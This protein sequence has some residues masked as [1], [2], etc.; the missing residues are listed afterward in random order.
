MIKGA[1]NIKNEIQAIIDIYKARDLL[2]AELFCKKLLAKHPKTAFLF[3]LLGLIL[4]EQEKYEEAIKTYTEGIKADPKFAMIYNNLGL[5]Y[6][7]YKSDKDKAEKFFKKSISIDSN[8][9]EP[10]NNLGTLYNSLDRFMEAIDCYEKAIK[11]NPNFVQP[12]HN[13][14][15]TYTT[16]GKFKEA[17]KHFEESLKLDPS[18]S[19]SHRS[20]SRL[21]K[22]KNIQD[23]HFKKMIK[24]YDKISDKDLE[25]KSNMSFALGKAYE[26]IK[27]FDKSYSYYNKANLLYRKKIH[28]SVDEE[29]SKFKKLKKVFNKSFLEKYENNNGNK[30]SPIFILGMPRSGTT[31]IEQILSN[32]P[33]VFGADEVEF[34]PD[35]YI[36]NLGKE[37][38]SEYLNKIKNLNKDKFKIIG[39]SYENKMNKY[40][41]NSER[42][43]DKLPANFLFIGFI[44]LILPN[45][46]VV[47][48][49]RNSKDNCLSL[50]KNHFPGTKLSFA[51]DMK[52][53]IEYYNLYADLMNYWNNLLPNFILNLSYEKLILD[54]E[55][56]IKNLLNFCDLDWSSKCIDFYNNKK[57]IKTASDTQARSKIYNSSVN[58]WKNYKNYLSKHFNKL[59]S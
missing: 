9:A 46:K 26:D 14:G 29:K 38:S 23:V 54:S 35:L 31:L 1:E 15:N 13:I 4:S 58:S 45:A 30:Y 48:C 20:L 27:E 51:Y 43:T 18:Y 37:S 17:K 55:H 53:I 11:I 36:E 49:Y 2:K 39:E 25:N 59:V 40:S 41:N 42:S 3:N 5:L 19:N 44:K 12:H 50:F 34:I 47:H 21:N 24:V 52:D 32:H 57:P 33:K 8:I 7:N 6:F 16:L 10:L 28:F 22:Y 56:E